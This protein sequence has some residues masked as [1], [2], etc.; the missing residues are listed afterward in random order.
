MLLTGGIYILCERK[1]LVAGDLVFILLVC[2]F[3]GFV[4]LS[5]PIGPGSYSA[6]AH[7][8]LSHFLKD[9]K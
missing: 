8:A 2:W 5:A 1:W 6:C 7:F 4:K 9:F 3:V